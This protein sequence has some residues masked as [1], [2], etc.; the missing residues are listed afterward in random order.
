M[1]TKIII[2]AVVT[3]LAVGIGIHHFGNCPMKGAKACTA[4]QK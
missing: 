1:R 2:I 3:L 4:A